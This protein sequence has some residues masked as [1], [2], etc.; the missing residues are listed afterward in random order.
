MPLQTPRRTSQA[1][2][3]TPFQLRPD[4]R[5]AILGKTGTGKSQLAMFLDR[6]W[7]AAGW[8]VLIVDPK[9]RYLNLRDGET[10]AE[11]PESASVEHPLRIDG[12]LRE[13]ARV[14]IYLPTLPAKRDTTLDALFYQVIDRGS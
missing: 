10:Y 12:K 8:L 4:E 11:G 7:M 2:R 13:D 14:Q 5:W 6:R 3:K 9:H 1:L